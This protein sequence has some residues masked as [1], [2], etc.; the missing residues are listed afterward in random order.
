MADHLNSMHLEAPRREQ[1]RQAR[2]KLIEACG[3]RTR[4]AIDQDAESASPDDSRTM[5]QNLENRLPSGTECALMDKESIYPL[6]IGLNT[7]GR[8]PDNDIVLED[9]YVSRRHCAI[10]VHASNSFELHD[11][12]SKNGTYLN[13]CRLSG[14]TPLASGD[15]IRMCDR[16][17]IFVIK[18]DPN[19]PGQAHTLS[20]GP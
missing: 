9:P 17:L 5:I 20:K 10:L 7:I 15:E 14:P 13:G 11:V 18:H 2:A 12:A 6:K 3:D 4:C 8:L 1:F 19:Q 16:Q